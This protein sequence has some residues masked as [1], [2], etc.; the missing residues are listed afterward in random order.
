MSRKIRAARN[1]TS[2]GAW[3]VGALSVP[4]V[5]GLF[6]RLVIPQVNI[7]LRLNRVLR[8]DLVFVI[9]HSEQ[10]G[11]TPNCLGAAQNQDAVGFETV[12]Q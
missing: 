2:A 6:D 3:D 8:V 12:M 4:L 1:S 7:Q 11:S 9:Q 10:I 5:Q